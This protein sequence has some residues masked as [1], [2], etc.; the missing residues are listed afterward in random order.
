M[1][2]LK[3]LVYICTNFCFSSVGLGY[4]LGKLKFLAKG[5]LEDTDNYKSA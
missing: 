4:V 1:K 5:V 3:E 2:S